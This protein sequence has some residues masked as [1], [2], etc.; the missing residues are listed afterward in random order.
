MP[1]DNSGESAAIINAKT[2]LADPNFRFPQRPK[3]PDDVFVY[4]M[5]DGLGVQVRGVVEPTIIR[6]KQASEAI[7]FIASISAQGLSLP[8]ILKSAPTTVRESAILRAFIILHSR[9]LIV[10]AAIDGSGPDS[11]A[12]DTV[13]GKAALFWSRHLGASGS[14]ASAAVVAQS[15]A[16]HKV[17]LFGDGLFGALLLEALVRSGFS[18]LVVLNWRGCS[19]IR[20]AFSSLRPILQH[21]ECIEVA[22]ATELRDIERDVREPD[23]LVTALR[24]PPDDL[25]EEVNR[26]C[27]RNRWRF[28]MGAETPEYFE[29]GPFVEPYDSACFT[30]A[31]LRRRSTMEFPIEERLFQKHWKQE[32]KGPDTEKAAALNGE[33]TAS[34]LVPVGILAMECIRIATTILLPTLLNAQMTFKPLSGELAKNRILRVPRCPDC[35]SQ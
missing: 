18:N 23:L 32:A 15:L 17:T 3:L 24:I 34:A 27:L 1:D 20:D 35:Q 10:D 2:T 8:E 5:P 22:S 31:R 7:Q 21:A 30:C 33:A 16:S 6:G 19:I 11:G 4:V 14:C 28:L 25:F 9:G 13:D 29:I 26:H 12:A